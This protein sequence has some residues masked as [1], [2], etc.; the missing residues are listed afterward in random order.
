MR[1][2]FLVSSIAKPITLFYCSGK[3]RNALEAVGRITPIVLRVV[4]MELLLI[5]SFAAVACRLYSNFESFRDL[6]TAWLSLFQ[7]KYCT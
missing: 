4:A 6:S 1:G 3:A 7:C 5:L 2:R